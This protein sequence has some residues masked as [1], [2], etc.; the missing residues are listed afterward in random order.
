MSTRTYLEWIT[1]IA[2]LIFGIYTM[3][4]IKNEK[5]KYLK[6]ARVVSFKNFKM[7]IP[8]WWSDV[9]E[10][11]KDTLIFKRLDTRY[12]WQASFHW[13]EEN[14]PKDIIE[15]FK[16]K[17]TERKILFD[18]ETSIIYNP[19]DF[20]NSP[21]TQSGLFEIVRLEGTATEDKS[22]R[23]YYD[24]FLVRQKSNGHYLFAQSKSSVLNGLVEGPYFEEV[25]LRLEI[26]S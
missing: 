6:D 26:K 22:E 5:N 15:L 2:L 23:L 11:M 13:I 14:S 18:E 19:S 17:I 12:D 25:M 3:W 4:I 1:F 24:A 20:K 7:L 21:L 9:S 8:A 16:D 10:D